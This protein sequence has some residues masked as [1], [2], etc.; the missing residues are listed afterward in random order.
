[1]TD[2]PGE[3]S[4]LW[5]YVIAWLGACTGLCGDHCRQGEI[6]CSTPEN[7]AREDGGI[8]VR[9]GGPPPCHAMGQSSRIYLLSLD[10]ARL[11]RS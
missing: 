11:P 4:S 8:A 6:P 1:M 3:S 9:K 5:G 7:D 2:T 10:E